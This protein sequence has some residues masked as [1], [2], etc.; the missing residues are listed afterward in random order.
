[1]SL[2]AQVVSVLET[3][4]VPYALIGAAALAGIQPGRNL[5]CSTKS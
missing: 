4:G 5:I 2:L 3:A 1:M